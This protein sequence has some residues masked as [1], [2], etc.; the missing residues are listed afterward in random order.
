MWSI[1]LNFKIESQNKFMCNIGNVASQIKSILVTSFMA[2]L[3]MSCDFVY[4]GSIIFYPDI[5][6][7]I[8]HVKGFER[9]LYF[10]FLN[11]FHSMPFLSSKGNF[12]NSI[13]LITLGDY[14][15]LVTKHYT[16]HRLLLLRFCNYFSLCCLVTD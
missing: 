1:K 5:P 14:M 7:H 13:G 15:I 11:S 4:K 9:Y 12:Y 8:I 10:F 3:F 6:D 2:L 16:G